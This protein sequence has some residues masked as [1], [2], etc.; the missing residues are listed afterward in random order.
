MIRN[1]FDPPKHTTT[2][3]R[4]RPAEYRCFN[5]ST[6]SYYQY[7]KHYSAARNRSFICSKTWEENEAGDIYAVGGK[8][9]GCD[10]IDDGNRGVNRQLLH[11]FNGVWLIW[12]HLV[13]A[14]DKKGKA[15]LDKN[16]KPAMDRI[17]CK[18]RACDL[19]KQKV[20]KVFGNPVHFS[21][22]ISHL[23]NLVGFSEE[24]EKH[25]ACGGLITPVTYGCV[26]CGAVLLD[27]T[28]SDLD[29]ESLGKWVKKA[30]KCPECETVAL[31][32]PENECSG[33]GNPIPLSIFD[34][35][36]EIKKHG[37]QKSS[38][39]QI[40]R[41]TQKELSKELE[42]MPMPDLSKVLR[43]SDFE[44]QAKCLGIENP[45]GAEKGEKANPDDH[46]G[47]YDEPV[48]DEVEY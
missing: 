30:H 18:G 19:C 6:S 3:F 12:F 17:P 44:W 32:I 45:Y 14:E 9:L 27:V 5:G 13:P 37:E 11:G 4:F 8:C 42:E 34:V 1:R 48:A 24:I 7:F 31:A 22:G 41:W 16:G 26:K 47:E 28:S 21:V 46:A 40:P 39:I 2:P 36:V 35:D 23:N 20:E 25:C 15:I 38:S 10:E 33:C 29:D 43:G